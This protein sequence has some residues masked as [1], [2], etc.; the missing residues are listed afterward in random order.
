VQARTMVA[1]TSPLMRLTLLAGMAA[2]AFT[3]VA[4][5]NVIIAATV[6]GTIVG[7]NDLD[8]YGNPVGSTDTTGPFGGAGNNL[9]GELL[10]L[11]F[12]Y[13]ATQMTSN[14]TY[15]ND[16]V[17]YS[18]L[19]DV[20]NDGA[21]TSTATVAGYQPFTGAGDYEDVSFIDNATEPFITAPYEQFGFSS[22]NFVYNPTLGYNIYVGVSLTAYYLPPPSLD[23][24][25]SDS[26]SVGAV[27]AQGGVPG[28]FFVTVVGPSGASDYLALSTSSVSTPE[29]TTWLL[30]ATGLGGIALL[31]FR[32]SKSSR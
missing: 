24:D 14:G 18:Y 29:P 21:L 28:G 4:H 15:Y 31:K 30:L 19:Y 9:L 22:E 1:S 27:M 12:S 3:G 23:Y 26:A 6:T 17:G 32:R 7:A 25:V 8:P 16:G 10:T 11:S 2:L 5:A 13:D 20:S